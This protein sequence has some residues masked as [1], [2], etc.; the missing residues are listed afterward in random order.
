MK[1]LVAGDYS[2]RLRLDSLLAAHEFEAVLG[3]VK[4][5][6]HDVDFG[7]VNFE[8]SL[9]TSDSQPIIKYGPNCRCIDE[10]VAALRWAGFN[11]ATLANNHCRDYGGK[12]L[13]HTIDELQ[14]N[15][16]YT[17]G[18]GKNLPDADKVLYLKHGSNI[19][20]VIN[21]CEHEFTV[22]TDSEA[23]ANPLDPV[24]QYYSIQEARRLADYV[25]VIVHGGHENFQYPSLR[26]QDTYRFFIDAGAD[27]VINH[28]QHCISGIEEYHGK[29]IFY[30]LGNFLFDTDTKE[31]E[32]IWNYG[33]M[34]RLDLNNGDIGYDLIPY[35]HCLEA[36]SVS[37]IDGQRM[38]DEVKE[39]SAVI[40]DRDKLK[41]VND[42]YRISRSRGVMA[43]LQ[44]YPSRYLRAIYRELHLLPSILSKR[45]VLMLKNMLDCESHRD[46][47]S[48]VLE[49]RIGTYRNGK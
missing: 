9:A 42:E 23:G 31:D 19:A 27:V 48:S 12:A 18:A 8:G 47:C 1:L 22:A 2:P 5:I 17:V 24:R 35:S 11:V 29:P 30:G 3:E 6:L 36:P 45:N 20:A 39:I 7:I 14:R 28:H 43:S 41:Q 16:I 25:I 13:M 49:Q 37:I 15:D 38:L 46:V 10:S 33:Y 32:R 21:C 26:M 4:K 44:P 40:A 34:V